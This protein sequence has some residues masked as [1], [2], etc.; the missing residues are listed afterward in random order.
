MV[1]ASSRGDQRALGAEAALA[2]RQLS[3]ARGDVPSRRFCATG[4]P[5]A[6]APAMRNTASAR[7]ASSLRPAVARRVLPQR[8]CA[9]QAAA[10]HRAEPAAGARP[11]ACGRGTGR[12]RARAPGRAGRQRSRTRWRPPRARPST[13]TRAIRCRRT[14][15]SS[16]A[17]VGGLLR[18]ERDDPHRHGRQQIRLIAA[19]R[20]AAD[21]RLDV[22]RDLDAGM[23]TSFPKNPSPRSRACTRYWM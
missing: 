18:H 14:C 19:L 9:L 16:V 20:P 12:R 15:R 7:P 23:S 21:G 11:T 2:H 22:I 6:T 5:S 4:R 8:G 10:Q 13:Q 1:P 3:V 17:D